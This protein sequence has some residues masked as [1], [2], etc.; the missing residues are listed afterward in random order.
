MATIHEHPAPFD[1]NRQ[2]FIRH[3]IQDGRQ[4]PP[5]RPAV[6][7][8]VQ[9]AH[10]VPRERFALVVHAPITSASPSGCRGGGFSDGSPG[11]IGGRVVF[12]PVE[13]I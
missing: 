12:L 2:S 13:S 1:G 9:G 7:G 4:Q 3:V 10:Q 5:T 11:H 6:C 8:V